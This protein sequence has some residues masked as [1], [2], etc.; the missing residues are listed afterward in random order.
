MSTSSSSE[1]LNHVHA[2]VGGVQ[3]GEILLGTHRGMSVSED[4][5]LTW[6]PVPGASAGGVATLVRVVAGGYLAAV[7]QGMDDNSPASIL[8]SVDGRRWLPSTG[9]EPNSSISNLVPGTG[10]VAWASVSGKG[11]YRS[12]DSGHSWSM[13]MPTNMLMTA[14][15]DTGEILVF[16]DQ[17]GV[18]VT[19]D[20]R[21]TLPTA[22]AVAQAIN[23][24]ARWSSCAAC[25]VVTPTTGGVTVSRDDGRTWQP[26]Q[27]T[28]SG[29]AFDNVV[30]FP[31]S[32]VT[33]FGMVAT[34][35]D[36]HEGLWRSTDGGRSWAQV[37]KQPNV[38]NMFA[39][40][41]PLSLVAFQWGIKVWRSVDGGATWTQYSSL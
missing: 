37:L 6:R 9:L 27:V 15:Y 30:S 28:P 19:S 22:P 41:S 3:P 14:L 17:K 10:T 7:L 12:S 5:G 18:Y 36:P 2:A 25:L 23:T 21:P 35:S 8:Y 16:A 33:L 40:G 24:V 1:E 29:L 32:G 26:V 20:T 39:E 34:P 38:D 4:A 13:A 31:S 11:V